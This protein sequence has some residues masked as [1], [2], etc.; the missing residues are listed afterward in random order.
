MSAAR[1]SF[2]RLASGIPPPI[3]HVFVFRSK[4]LTF[5]FNVN[6]ISVSVTGSSTDI[7]VSWLFE[8]HGTPARPHS[9]VPGSNVIIAP[10][11]KP[12]DVAVAGLAT[13]SGVS[14]GQSLM[15]MV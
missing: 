8:S 3:A 11:T 15:V 7:Q 9:F 12:G 13:L 10:L 4:M 1:Y 2:Q 5:M 14:P 6:W